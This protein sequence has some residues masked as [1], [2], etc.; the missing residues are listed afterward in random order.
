MKYIFVLSS[1]FLPTDHHGSSHRV[2]FVNAGVIQHL[3][4]TSLELSFCLLSFEE[5]ISLHLALVFSDGGVV[6]HLV[7]Q[8]LL[9][10]QSALIHTMSLFSIQALILLNASL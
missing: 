2:K 5:L 7:H 1:T 8:V 9:V 6:G 3:L 10:S 4:H